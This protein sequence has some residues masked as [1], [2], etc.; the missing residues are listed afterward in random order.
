MMT[1]AMRADT[2]RIV[3]GWLDP[4]GTLT[5][6]FTVSRT[7]PWFL[8]PDP[9]AQ[10]SQPGL[11][12]I[13]DSCNVAMMVVAALSLSLL[14]LRGGLLRNVLCGTVAHRTTAHITL[15]GS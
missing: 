15:R 4:I 14:L 10:R 2:T 3:R 13:L 9:P 5:E 12:L 7:A 11:N 8:A 6:K 1:E